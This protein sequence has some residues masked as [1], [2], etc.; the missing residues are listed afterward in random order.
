V[1]LAAPNF[2]LLFPKGERVELAFEAGPALWF[3]RACTAIGIFLCLAV[4]LPAARPLRRRARLAVDALAASPPFRGLTGLARASGAWPAAIRHRVL[5]GGIAVV[6]VALGAFVASTSATDADGVYRKGQ[7]MY[8]E[9]KLWESLPYFIEAQRLAPLSATAMHARYFEAIIYFRES[10]WDE[11]ERRFRAIVDG[12]PES[13]NAP[14]AFYHVGLCRLRQGD[15][16]GA[17]AA[18]EETV[19]RFPESNWAGF[20]KERLAETG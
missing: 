6:A 19:R 3:G 2:M 16:A 10:K 12:F 18:W 11:A 9:G 5:G 8:G 14:E 7:A 17:V 15:S 13:P 4:T 20:A 1:W